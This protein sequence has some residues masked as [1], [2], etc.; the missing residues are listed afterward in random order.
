MLDN[1]TIQKK[2]NFFLNKWF[3]FCCYYT[4]KYDNKVDNHVGEQL[5]LNLKMSYQRREP[6]VV[7]NKP[8]VL[9]TRLTNALNR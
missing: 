7:L 9:I 2:N 8:K 1:Q 4:T 5:I 6:E 3:K